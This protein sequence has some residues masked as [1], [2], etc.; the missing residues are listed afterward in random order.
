MSF[1]VRS[2]LVDLLSL[3]EKVVV[4]VFVKADS[5]LC[6][7]KLLSSALPDQARGGMERQL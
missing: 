2:I 7:Q 6:D 3:K 5:Q 1:S 4:S